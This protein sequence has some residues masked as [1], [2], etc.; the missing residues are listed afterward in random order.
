MKKFK[1]R[2]ERSDTQFWEVKARS[3]QEAFDNYANG[4]LCQTNT[5]GDVL[6]VVKELADG[7]ILML[8]TP[9]VK[10][11]DLLRILPKEIIDEC[12]WHADDVIVLTTGETLLS[13]GSSFKSMSLDEEHDYAD[14][15]SDGESVPMSERELAGYIVSNSVE[16]LRMLEKED[17]SKM[18]L[19]GNQIVREI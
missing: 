19:S 14:M 8:S 4:N 13:D 1:V 10:V 15:E 12:E 9:K 5:H 16:L 2:V 3:E 7:R 17:E 11:S 18:E 6:S